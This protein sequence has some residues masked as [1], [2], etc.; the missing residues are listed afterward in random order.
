MISDTHALTKNLIQLEHSLD[1]ESIQMFV[2][3]KKHKQK[4]TK[5][6]SL[7]PRALEKL[8]QINLE[9]NGSR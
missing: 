2:P 6:T 7:N 3:M 1:L 4:T 5:T 9:L 8:I